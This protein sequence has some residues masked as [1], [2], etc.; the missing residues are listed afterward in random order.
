MAAA[1]GEVHGRGAEAMSEGMVR[2]IKR[3]WNW[4]AEAGRQDETN[5]ADGVMLKLVAPPRTRVELGEEAK[6][7][8]DAGASVV[9][10]H[11]RND[12]GSPTFSPAMFAPVRSA[13][14]SEVTSYPICSRAAGTSSPAPGR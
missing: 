12:D 3:F 8:Y 6:R 10:I 14:V 7:A 9:H 5:V 11:A 2:V 4:L 13:P 1:I